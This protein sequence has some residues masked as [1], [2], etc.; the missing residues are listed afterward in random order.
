MPPKKKE[1]IGGITF[2]A[3]LVEYTH[4]YI[5]IELEIIYLEKRSI[6]ERENKSTHYA[7][8]ISELF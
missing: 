5:Y 4:I 7:P 3:P 1:K 8:I 2:E 6:R